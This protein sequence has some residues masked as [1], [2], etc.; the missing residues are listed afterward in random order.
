MKEKIIGY[1]TLFFLAFCAVSSVVLLNGRKKGFVKMVSRPKI[2]VVK[3]Y[4]VISVAPSRGPSVFGLR[5]SDK[6]VREL[7]SLRKM[8]VRAV[9][10]RVNSPGGS[11]GACQEIVDE[12]EKLKKDKIPVVASFGD[13]A[14]SGGYYISSVCDEIVLNQGTITGSIGVL[15][16]SS[17]WEKLLDK[18][19]IQP[20]VVKSG[21]YKDMG[22]YWRG[23]TDEERQLIKEL[24]DDSY[25]QFL[26]TVSKGRS[27]PVEKLKPL[28]QGQIFTGAQAISLGLADKIGNLNDAIEEAK[29]LT[30][31]K[32]EPNIVEFNRP[33]DR[34]LNFVNSPESLFDL[35]PFGFA[36][37]PLFLRNLSFFGK[38][39]S[40]L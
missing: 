2:G 19:G 6:I 27:I 37:I 14:A 26:N 17:N 1:L 12:I 23:F 9:V 16:G 32:G 13:V 28:A 20:E 30:G 38:K 31:I 3:V 8:K 22:A 4:G 34:L 40:G 29:R 15:M 18:I 25:G 5:G 21:K 11:I 10:L 33:F 24:I 7:D 39:G 35:K 36:D